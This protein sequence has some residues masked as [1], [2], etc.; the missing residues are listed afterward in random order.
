MR[1]RQ[2]QG[3]MEHYVRFLDLSTILKLHYRIPLQATAAIT[4]GQWY[5][6]IFNNSVSIVCQIPTQ[7]ARFFKWNWSSLFHPRFAATIPVY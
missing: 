4:R 1:N 3:G 7:G 2:Q 6:S 5:Q